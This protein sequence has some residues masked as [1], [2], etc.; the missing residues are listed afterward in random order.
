MNEQIKELIK[1][2]INKL[3]NESMHEITNE[4]IKEL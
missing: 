2:W 4:Q 3:K 1:T